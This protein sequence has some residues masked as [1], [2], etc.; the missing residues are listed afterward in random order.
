[1]PIYNFKCKKCEKIFEKICKMGDYKAE[2]IC[3]SKKVE[4]LLTV[5]AVVFVNAKES[6]KY[7]NFSYK[8][9]ALMEKAKEE[10]RFAEEHDH[11]G[12]NPYG[13]KPE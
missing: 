4:Q 8:A 3:G 1:M 9:G 5:P 12:V 2:C 7:D 11:M 13:D 10:R 6:S